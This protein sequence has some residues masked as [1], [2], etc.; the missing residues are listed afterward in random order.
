MKIEKVAYRIN[1]AKFKKGTSIFV[2]CINEKE[3][4]EQVARVMKRL[5]MDYV[6]KVVIED[7]IKGLRIWR[8]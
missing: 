2:P 3:A 1:W 8:M 7:G 4:K 6:T 5:R